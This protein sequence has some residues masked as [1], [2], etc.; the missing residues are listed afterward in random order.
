MST[1]EVA[2]DE[3][4]D[5]VNRL[6]E[7]YRGDL[8]NAGV[9]FAVLMAHAKRDKNGKPKGSALKLGGYACLATVRITSLADR[10]AGLAD[11]V[12]TID[13]DRWQDLPQRSRIAVLDHEL[14]H[15]DLGDEIDYDDAGRPKIKMRKHDHQFGW[16]DSVVRRHG[17]HAIEWQQFDEFVRKPAKQL[18]L[19]FVKESFGELRQAMSA[20]E[21]E[22]SYS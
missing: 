12:I 14:T 16:F 1:Y 21:L 3:T 13:G 10:V 7:K 18:W 19:P 6:V 9:E 17:I 2:P 8:K 22:E 11:V 5:Q 15:L 20:E 4:V